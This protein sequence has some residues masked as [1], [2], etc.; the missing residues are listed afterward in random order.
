M[1]RYLEQNDRRATG[2]ADRW[3]RNLGTEG[4]MPREASSQS[5]EQRH[6]SGVECSRRTWVGAHADVEADGGAQAYELVDADGRDDRTLDPAD[7]HAGHV[8]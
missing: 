3:Q 7:L 8:R 5:M 1:G 2:I 4:Q 6:L